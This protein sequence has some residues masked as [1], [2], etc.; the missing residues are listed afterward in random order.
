MVLG[1]QLALLVFVF[2]F[3]FH[4]ASGDDLGDHLPGVFCV[5]CAIFLR[6]IVFVPLVQVE[7]RVMSSCGSLVC[8]I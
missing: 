2:L 3:V 6:W 4:G 8:L 5:I 1:H 7:P